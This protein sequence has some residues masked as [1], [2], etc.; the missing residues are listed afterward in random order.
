MN[1]ETLESVKKFVHLGGA[2]FSTGIQVLVAHTNLTNPGDMASKISFAP[3][4]EPKFK[5]TGSVN[6][7]LPLLLRK[8]TI[9]EEETPQV[10]Q[11]QAN[12]LQELKEQLMLTLTAE[13]PENRKR[14]LAE[15]EEQDESIK[16]KQK[17]KKKAKSERTSQVEKI[18]KKLKK[19]KKVKN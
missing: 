17:K 1:P 13:E 5:T 9:G 19:T 18:P 12:P 7:L 8:S 14:K 4:P 2:L 3:D 15:R 6:D 10:V 11:Q 16:K